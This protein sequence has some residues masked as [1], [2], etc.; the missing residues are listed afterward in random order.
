[1]HGMSERPALTLRLKK[2]DFLE[3]YYLKEELVRFCRENGLPASGDK[4]ELTERI[5]HYLDTGKV[6]KTL[7]RF[8]MSSSP[9]EPSPFATTIGSFSPRRNGSSPARS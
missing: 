9:M 3:Y 8:S 1:M 2:R 4:K 5:A 7:G 6:K